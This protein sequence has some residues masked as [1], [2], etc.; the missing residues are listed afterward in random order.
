VMTSRSDRGSAKPR[1]SQRFEHHNVIREPARGL[2]Q[3]QQPRGAALRE[4]AAHMDAPNWYSSL[5]KSSCAAGV[6]HTWIYNGPSLHSYAGAE[7]VHAITSNR[8]N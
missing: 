4:Q 7:V 6:L 1:R 3:G 2:H 8:L 5:N